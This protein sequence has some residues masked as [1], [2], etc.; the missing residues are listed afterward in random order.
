MILLHAL[1]YLLAYVLNCVNDIVDIK[2]TN[3]QE[4]L[5]ELGNAWK[6]YPRGSK[7]T[8]RS[9]MR[10]VAKPLTQIVNR[11][12][13]VTNTKFKLLT[14]RRLKCSTKLASVDV[15]PPI[16]DSVLGNQKLARFIGPA[17]PFAN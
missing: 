5:R 9:A 15:E 1:T 2:V 10:K 14:I 12:F 11:T 13:N 8:A 4:L 3:V 17:K 6:L 16:V 7:I